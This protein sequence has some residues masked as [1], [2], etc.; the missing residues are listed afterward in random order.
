MQCLLI[1]ET[2]S[3]NRL[4][5]L[6][7]TLAYSGFTFTYLYRLSQALMD[8]KA[9]QQNIGTDKCGEVSQLSVVEEKVDSF[10]TIFQ[11]R[12]PNRSLKMSSRNNGKLFQ[13][14]SKGNTFL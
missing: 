6:D 7:S 5:Q 3:I 12:N 1:V 11:S 8:F 13:M 9:A 2:R 14:C 4:V 10:T